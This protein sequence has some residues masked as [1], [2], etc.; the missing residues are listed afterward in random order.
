[1]KLI[2]LFPE[3]YFEEKYLDNLTKVVK[4]LGKEDR[5]AVIA[6]HGVSFFTEIRLKTFNYEPY[7]EQLI[8]GRNKISRITK[9][10]KH[11]DY[12]NVLDSYYVIVY[13]R[14]DVKGTELALK[15]IERDEWK[16]KATVIWY[17]KEF[18]AEDGTIK[19][20]ISFLGDFFS[21]GEVELLIEPKPP[22]NFECDDNGQYKMF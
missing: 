4:K 19:N 22:K 16:N 3:L 6:S 14:K 2:V 12:H 18:A 9:K 11:L 7:F 15:Y 17:I 1:M 13:K 10:S 21:E 8:V 20:L 5:L